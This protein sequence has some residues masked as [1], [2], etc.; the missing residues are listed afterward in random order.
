ML[1]LKWSGAKEKTVKQTVIIFIVL[2]IIYIWFNVYSVINFKMLFWDMAII[3]KYL[4]IAYYL[5]IVYALYL[6]A[7]R[8]EES[9]W[10]AILWSF[11]LWP[12]YLLMLSF[13]PK[14][15]KIN[16]EVKKNKNLDEL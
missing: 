2:A 7:L 3:G 8:I 5:P 16:P 9:K 11:I 13:T 12:I 1:L 14:L 10:S 15:D 6:F 4:S